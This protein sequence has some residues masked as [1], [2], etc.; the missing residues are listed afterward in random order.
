[1]IAK[2]KIPLERVVRERLGEVSKKGEQDKEM[3][4]TGK[5]R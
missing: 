1:M 3:Q 4:M 2:I 5:K